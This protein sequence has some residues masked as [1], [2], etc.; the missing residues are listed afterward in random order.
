MLHKFRVFSVDDVDFHQVKTS[1]YRTRSVERVLAVLNVFIDAGSSLTLMQVCSAT[2]LTPST[3]YRLMANLVAR[4]Y[5]EPDRE[6]NAYRLGLTVIDLTGV[7]L[8]QLSVRV[9]HT[10]SREEL[11]NRTGATVHLAALDGRHIIY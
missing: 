11:R 8:G 10:P 5:L 1:A 7:T 2:G 9:R 3:A 6:G 4:G